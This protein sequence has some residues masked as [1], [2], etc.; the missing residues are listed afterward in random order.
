MFLK[1][2]LASI[3][4]SQSAVCGVK[5]KMLENG[6]RVIYSD[7]GLEYPGVVMSVFVRGGA[8][9][10]YNNKTSFAA[11]AQEQSVVSI[12]RLSRIYGFRYRTNISWDYVSYV[13]Y[14]QASSVKYSVPK[15]LSLFFVP[16]F[17]NQDQLNYLKNGV[18][19]KNLWTMNRQTMLYPLL[20]FFAP[21]GSVYS[22][23]FN[24]FLED[25]LSISTSEINTFSRCFFSA[26]NL[27]VSF[28]GIKEKDI[29]LEDMKT[30]KP[31]FKDG[32][33]KKQEFVASKSPNSEFSYY[34]AMGSGFIA[35]LGF[36]APNCK[37]GSVLY[38]VIAELTERDDR[39]NSLVD[40][41]SS[42]NNC[43]SGTGTIDFIFSGAKINLTVDMFTK[44]LIELSQRL[45]EVDLRSAK[46]TLLAKYYFRLYSKEDLSYLLAKTE[47]LCGN[48]KILMDYP[49]MLKKV[50][51][52]MVKQELL[53]LESSK[54]VYLFMKMEK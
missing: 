42:Q 22:P 30:Y 1:L 17:I 26:N 19:Q 23:G 21:R 16:P 47:I 4:I 49:S 44:E 6:L 14:L 8:S 29:P 13:F 39:I 31:C 41:F 54:H 5:S 9:L 25:A 24:G 3:I 10:S 32:S 18:E 52:E 20:S 46:E 50:S 48:Y 37:K 2:L 35:R 12:K 38:D 40:N 51:L 15:I 45:E 43:Y 27:V 53:R 11:M 7:T 36:I 33:F 34:K 28:A